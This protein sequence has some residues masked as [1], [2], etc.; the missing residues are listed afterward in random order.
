MSDVLKDDNFSNA[1]MIE[2]VGN[3]IMDDKAS[4]IS[5]SHPKSSA[6]TTT[7]TTT[8]KTSKINEFKDWRGKISQANLPEYRN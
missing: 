8:T 3:D 1:P 2:I 5:R 7:A 4:R 6:T